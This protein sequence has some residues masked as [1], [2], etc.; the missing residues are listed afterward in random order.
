MPLRHKRGVLF[1]SK[2]A[3]PGTLGASTTLPIRSR[4]VEV[5]DEVDPTMAT[6]LADDFVI[7]IP[8][9]FTTLPELRDGLI[10][11]SSEQQDETVQECLPF[12]AEPEGDLNVHGIPT[13]ARAKHVR[14]LQKMLEGPFPGG[15]VTV[16]AARPWMLYWALTGLYLLG[17][18]VTRYRD[19]VIATALT[20]QNKTGGFG[21]G[22]GQFSHIATSYATVLSLVYVSGKE[23]LDLID[24]KAMYVAVPCNRKAHH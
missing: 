9:L 21:G 14:F 23:A 1:S 2:M 20:M 18:E 8:A 17:E 22:G 5:T 7:P 11:E 19:R 4:I 24:R 10:T 16:D 13:L 3:P 15:F 6:N 12:L